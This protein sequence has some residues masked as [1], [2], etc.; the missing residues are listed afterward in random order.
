MKQSESIYCKYFFNIPAL[1]ALC[2]VYENYK[3]STVNLIYPF[4]KKWTKW[5]M[6]VFFS[7]GSTPLTNIETLGLSNFNLTSKAGAI[8]LHGP[9]QDAVKSMTTKTSLL[10][11]RNWSKSA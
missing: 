3:N 6:Y 10:S 7:T 9:H 2:G 1:I 4:P 8:F 11:S 5:G